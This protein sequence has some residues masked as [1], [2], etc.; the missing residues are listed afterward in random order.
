MLLPDTRHETHHSAFKEVSTIEDYRPSRYGT[1][2][3]TTSFAEFSPVAPALRSSSS[4]LAGRSSRVYHEKHHPPRRVTF[5]LPPCDGAE[6]SSSSSSSW[7][8]HPSGGSTAVGSVAEVAGVQS[9]LRS[10]RIVIQ[11][12]GLSPSPSTSHALLHQHSPTLLQQTRPPSPPTTS[13]AHTTNY[14]SGGTLPPPR[15]SARALPHQFGSQIAHDTAGYRKGTLPDTA[16][17]YGSSSLSN[18]TLVSSGVLSHHHHTHHSTTGSSYQ[19]ST[20]G[21]SSVLGSSSS[22]SSPLPYSTSSH[23]SSFAA[24]PPANTTAGGVALHHSPPHAGRRVSSSTPPSAPATE[25][26]TALLKACRDGEEDTV[27]QLIRRATLV[28]ASSAD[29]NVTDHTGRSPLSYLS[30]NGSAPM[31]EALA[32]LPGVD[33]NQAD[34]EGNTP[35]HFAAQAGHADILNILLSRCA[36]VDVDARNALG[37]TPLM[38]AALQGRTKCAKLLLIAGASPTLRDSGR[39][40]RAEQ[41]ARFCGRYVCAEAIEKLSKNRLLDRSG[42]NGR[43]GSEPAL[44]DAAFIRPHQELGQ[45]QSAGGAGGGG[46]G[47]SWLRSK[48]RRAFRS[49]TASVA[50]SEPTP[51]SSVVTQQLTSAALCASSPVLPATPAATAA[52]FLLRGGSGSGAPP[53]P[54]L[55]VTPA[56]PGSGGGVV[57]QGK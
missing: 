9:W 35:L 8:C 49:S 23:S 45:R 40:F 36:G 13:Y 24:L 4:V 27:M 56:V 54:K 44:G 2:S 53:V 39:G 6:S 15:S 48:L 5:D 7:G 57:L 46:G 20:R 30:S 32:V 14:G 10:R 21:S 51:N 42:A 25:L 47:S 41:W 22:S 3:F 19:F 43:W 34:T 28:G 50:I 16:R 17:L 38:K 12:R 29:L 37:F 33:A 52:K 11:S 55:H 1:R 26:G 18:S 31:V